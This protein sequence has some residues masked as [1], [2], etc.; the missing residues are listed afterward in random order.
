[1]LTS[2]PLSYV[3]VYLHPSK[4]HLNTLCFLILTFYRISFK[5]S[6]DRRIILE[7]NNSEFLYRQVRDLVWSTKAQNP[8]SPKK[9]KQEE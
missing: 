7:T 2:F 5:F 8:L 3:F 4:A 6:E 9:K 1:M